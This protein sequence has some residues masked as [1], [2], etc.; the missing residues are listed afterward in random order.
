M[1]DEGTKDAQK[2]E[3]LDKMLNKTLTEFKQKK[4]EFEN[5]KASSAD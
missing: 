2:D 5:L 4:E 1:I 3:V